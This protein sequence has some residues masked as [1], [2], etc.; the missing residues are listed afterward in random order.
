MV[1][2]DDYEF[3]VSAYNGINFQYSNISTK[4]L[5]KSPLNPPPSALPV[6]SNF[7]ASTVSSSRVNLSWSYDSYGQTGFTITRIDYNNHTIAFFE[8]AG[9]A[10]SFQDTGLIPKGSYGYKINA[11]NTNCDQSHSIG[12]CNSN[13]SSIVTVITPTV[14]IPTAP[15]GLSAT[16]ASRSQ[17]NLSWSDNSSNETGFIIERA[18]SGGS[19]VKIATTLTNATSYQ[20]ISSLSSGTTY[21]YRICAYNGGGNSAY[22][23]TVSATTHSNKAL[24]K[25]T[26][27]SSTYSSS[28]AAS[29]GN[30]GDITTRWCASPTTIPQWW[31]VDLGSSRTIS[32]AEVMWQYSGLYKYRIETSTNNSTWTTRADLTNNTNTAQTQYQSF[33]TTARYVRIY[34]TAVPSGCRASL[35]EFRVFGQ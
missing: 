25:T 14:A 7:T 29:K 31:K 18:V 28:Y 8:V 16:A 27:A 33:S 15:Y 35:Y 22:S 30:D 4:W 17:I 1:N 26:S 34:V 21:Q 9:T 24:N 2:G 23:G 20:D 32:G 12:N 13:Y 6:P 5:K 10:S 19:F 11:I 3:R